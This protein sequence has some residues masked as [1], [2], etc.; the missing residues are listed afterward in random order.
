[1]ER[2]R[3][4]RPDP[5]SSPAAQESSRPSREWCG[6]RT[7]LTPKQGSMTG[8]AKSSIRS[9]DRQAQTSNF[10]A[11][12]CPARHRSVPRRNFALLIAARKILRGAT[13]DTSLLAGS[14][15]A[16]VALI[17]MEERP[18]AGPVRKNPAHR[19]RRAAG[20]GGVGHRFSTWPAA[21]AA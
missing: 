14:I 11:L 5:E 18:L 21:P 13:D 9:A 19:H 12:D 6:Q 2:G 16:G 10:H 1:M 8:K 4:S 3:I 15:L 7:S 20:A 17:L